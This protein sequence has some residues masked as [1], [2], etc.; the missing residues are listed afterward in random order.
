MTKATTAS[1]EGRGKIV[2]AHGLTLKLPA[3]LPFETV[4]FIKGE[5]IDIAGFLG[6]VLGEDQVAKVW[7]AGLDIDQGTKLVE[8]VL[9]KYGL[10]AGE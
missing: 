5:D 4:R 6:T 8:S 7:E 2:K 9:E 3:K 10:E 1:S